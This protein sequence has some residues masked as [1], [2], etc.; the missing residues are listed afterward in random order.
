[1]EVEK[2]NKLLLEKMANI[3]KGKYQSGVKRDFGSGEYSCLDGARGLANH[4]VCRRQTE[5]AES[6]GVEEEAGR[7]TNSA[8]QQTVAPAVAKGKTKLQHNRL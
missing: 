4:F 8:R 6:D 3:V 7:L 1:M 2:C 5:A